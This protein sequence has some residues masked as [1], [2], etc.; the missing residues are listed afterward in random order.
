[1]EDSAAGSLLITG[2]TAP[3]ELSNLLVLSRRKKESPT[4]AALSL[5]LL[6][7]GT[8]PSLHPRCSTIP[9]HANRSTGSPPKPR[10]PRHTVRGC[11]SSRAARVPRGNEQTDTAKTR[12]ETQAP[13]PGGS[14]RLPPH[15]RHTAALGAAVAAG[16]PSPAATAGGG[17][18]RPHLPEAAEP[19]GGAAARA[20]EETWRRPRAG[21]AGAG[22]P[23]VRCCAWLGVGARPGLPLCGHGE[24][25][26]SGGW[27]RPFPPQQVYGRA[28]GLCP[29]PPL[30]PHGGGSGSLSPAVPQRPGRG[31][32]V[33]AGRQ[34]RGPA[35]P[36]PRR[37]AEPCGTPGLRGWPGG[38]LPPPR[39]WP[40][41]VSV[42]DFFYLVLRARRCG[43]REAGGALR[44]CCRCRSLCGCGGCLQLSVPISFPSPHG[45][46]AL[47]SFA[48][49]PPA[50]VGFAAELRSSKQPCGCWL[51]NSVSTT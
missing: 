37:G 20:E 25:R 29:L 34:R 21:A 46:D 10:V 44:G 23:Q 24:P 17:T 42:R 5:D 11:R 22:A 43:R 47:R 12:K 35:G 33:D 9:L 28:A 3:F 14:R 45:A 4:A 36:R 51:I 15:H 50:S 18:W 2:L 39:R 31:A 40:C 27:R 38:L 16:P 1:M 26:R 48:P 7:F 8:E 19:R 32:G 41:W 30:A 13:K 49:P 6:S